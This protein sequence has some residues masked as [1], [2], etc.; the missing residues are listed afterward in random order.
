MSEEFLALGFEKHDLNQFMEW[1]LDYLKY[2]NCF[3]K[4]DNE[5]YKFDKM[6]SLLHFPSMYQSPDEK[7]RFQP[8]GEA[9]R[10]AS[11]KVTLFE[12]YFK[13]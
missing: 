5:P 3:P 13:K 9:L 6:K 10:S 4:N 11:N 8:M 1:D 12:S 2:D 7:T